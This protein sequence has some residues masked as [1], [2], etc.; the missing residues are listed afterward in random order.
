MRIL[1]IDPAW[2]LKNP[3]GFALIEQNGD[4]WQT[5]DIAPSFSL[6][7]SDQTIQERFSGKI[8]GGRF[9]LK[10]ILEKSGPV[11][12]IVVDMPIST[13]PFSGRREADN[14]IAK[15]YGNAWCAT[16]TPTVAI[17]KF[18]VEF[19]SEAEKYGYIL[20]TN[21]V[22]TYPHPAILSLIPELNKRLTYKVGKRKRYWPE[23]TPDERRENLYKNLQ[24]LRT[25]LSSHINLPKDYNLSID[26][27]FA[28][29]KSFEDTLDALVCAWV[30]I[31]FMNKQCRAFGDALSSIWIPKKEY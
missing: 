23:A 21:L 31:K 24:I 17:S 7:C 25:A 11:D 14:A 27:P 30:G 12:C 26:A 2:T 10:E 18:G 3:S 6:F 8:Y 20:N 15:D 4:V 1:G 22:E 5:K 28:L 19:V 29:L 9:S 16:H 13:K